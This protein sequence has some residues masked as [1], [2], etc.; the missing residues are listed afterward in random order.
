MTMDGL[1]QTVEGAVRMWE[2]TVGRGM[3]LTE[4]QLRLMRAYPVL[5]DSLIQQSLLMWADEGLPRVEMGHK[6]AAMLMCTGM[7]AECAATL[8]MPWRTFMVSVPN[9]MIR[10][11]FPKDSDDRK[12]SE[13]MIEADLSYV[14]LNVTRVMDLQGY[15]QDVTIAMFGSNEPQCGVFAEYTQGGFAHWMGLQGKVRGADNPQLGENSEASDKLVTDHQHDLELVSRL[16]AGVIAE[17]EEYRPSPPPRRPG[18]SSGPPTAKAD[19]EVKTY[20]V[21]LTSPIEMD[22]RDEVRTY[23]AGRASGKPTVRC[24]V[25]A[26]WKMQRCGVQGSERRRIRVSSHWRGASDAPVALRPHVV[27]KR[28]DAR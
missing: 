14:L 22:C 16:I 5:A 9:G 19:G 15:E 3:E 17:M 4:A 13:G 10:L 18:R 25:M 1:K 11:P 12:R 23:R 24:K 6:H 26:H 20:R 28:E 2:A 27:G 8:E 21:Q 7:T